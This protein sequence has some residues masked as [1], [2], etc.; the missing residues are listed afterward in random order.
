VHDGQRYPVKQII[1]MATGVTNFSGGDEAN[2]YVA[3]RGLSVATLEGETEVNSL[4]IRHGLEEIL[5][6]YTSARANERVGGHGLQS[7]FK[8]LSD[9]IA[10]TGAVGKRPDLVVKPS[11][12]LGNWAAIPWVAVFD[13][14]ETSTTRRGVYCVYLFREDMIGVY[15]ALAQGVDELGEDL[16][17]VQARKIFRARAEDT[18]LTPFSTAKPKPRVLAAKIGGESKY[19]IQHGEGWLCNSNGT[20][21]VKF[22]V[23][24]E[25]TR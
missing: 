7:T 20:T 9:A 19:Y 17:A 24:K 22:T 1:R 14:R 11:R 12:G 16:G 8:E 2:N 3:K 23:P 4:S 10:A 15:L 6:R 25:G 13:T 21:Q 5:A 18:P